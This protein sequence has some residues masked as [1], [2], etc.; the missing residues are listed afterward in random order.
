VATFWIG[1]EAKKCAQ[2]IAPL[3]SCREP[4]RWCGLG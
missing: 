1:M 3:P 2:K 4:G